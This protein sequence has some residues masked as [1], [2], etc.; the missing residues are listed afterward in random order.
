MEHQI[1]TVESQ[2]ELVELCQQLA[3]ES[4]LAI[5]TEFVRT[6]TLFPKLG[7]LQVGSS[8]VTACIDPLAVDDLTPFWQ[9]LT[10]NNILKVLHACSEDLEVFATSGNITIN[11]MLDSQIMMAFLDHG[12]S[13]GYAATV[14]HFLD[15][16]LDKTESRTDWIKRPL[17]DN[18]IQY[19]AA[20]VYYLYRLFPKLLAEIEAKGYL[21]AVEEES[22]QLINKK[23][24]V[25]DP[26][27][28]YQD[29]KLSWKLAPSGL[30]RLKHLANWRYIQAV[31][32]DLPISFVAKDPTLFTLA[33]HDP[34]SVSAM[35]NLEGCDMQDVRYKGKAMLNVLKAARADSPD[36][37]PE[38]IERLDTAAGY[39]QIFKRLKNFLSQ[40]ADAN[41]VP[42]AVL[43]SKKQ[44]NQLLKWQFNLNNYRQTNERIDLLCGW[45]HALIGEQLAKFIANNYQ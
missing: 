9:L 20:D 42:M 31:K 8:Q 37:Y 39:K 6:R 12:I 17:S 11:N 28:L 33:L 19:A 23:A 15:V 36:D 1:F 35:L 2:T 41:Q 43:A 25:I 4:V 32:R 18:Q 38:K 16:E 30:N 44:M 13:V 24:Q 14:K 5:D 45:R 10:N 29:V 26:M 40:Q 27:S 21:T 3:E 7:L 22:L 34:K